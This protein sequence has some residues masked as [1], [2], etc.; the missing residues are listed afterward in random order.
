MPEIQP[1]SNWALTHDDVMHAYFW[2]VEKLMM[3]ISYHFLILA[4]TLTC[5]TFLPHSTCPLRWT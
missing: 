3:L 4:H 5:S 2:T 1:I